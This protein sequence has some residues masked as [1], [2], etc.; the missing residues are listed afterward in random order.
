MCTV[1]LQISVNALILSFVSVLS[2][3]R[4]LILWLDDDQVSSCSLPRGFAW[5]SNGMR[6]SA[7]FVKQ[8]G[9]VSACMCWLS[10]KCKPKSDLPLQPRTEPPLRPFTYHA[11]PFPFRSF[12][13]KRNTG[14]PNSIQFSRAH[15]AAA[16]CVAFSC[17]CF[18]SKL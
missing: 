10:R 11:V 17:Y 18:G 14:Q 13:G 1:F 2:L 4:T 8:T 7:L 5:F 9:C 6:N 12:H 3:I 16:P 15:E